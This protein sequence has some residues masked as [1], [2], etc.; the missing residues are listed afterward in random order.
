MK[1]RE[2]DTFIVFLRT[3]FGVHRRLKQNVHVYMIYANTPAAKNKSIIN[4]F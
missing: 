3:I 1:K 4:L 2:R